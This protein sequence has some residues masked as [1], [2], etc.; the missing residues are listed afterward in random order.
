MNEPLV[1]GCFQGVGLLQAPQMA[2]LGFACALSTRMGG[3]TTGEAASMN[4][5]FKR[6]DT[7]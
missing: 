6:K 7:E 5:S 4:L 2:S 3:V 1:Y